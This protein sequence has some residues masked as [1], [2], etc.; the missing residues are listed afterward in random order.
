MT[1]PHDRDVL[2]SLEQT[3]AL[4]EA[5]TLPPAVEVRVDRVADTIRD[6]LELDSPAPTEM[7][8]VLASVA[9]GCL[10]ERVRDYQRLPRAYADGRAVAAGRTTLM[11]L[12]DTLDELGLTLDRLYDAVCREDHPALERH[13]RH[14]AEAFQSPS[15]ASVEEVTGL[16]QGPTP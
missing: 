12:V 16:V 3:Q 4:V 10:A 1:A 6:L 14:L 2:G 5:G 7:R 9:H 13:S 11:A 8:V 15:G